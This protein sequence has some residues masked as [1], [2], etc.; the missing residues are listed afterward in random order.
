MKILEIKRHLNKPDESY[1]CD[2]LARGSDYVIVK[3][4]SEMSVESALSFL[5]RDRQ[6]LHI[7][8]PV[9][10][11]LSGRCWTRTED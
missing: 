10:G 4:V 2:L 1:L 6:L 11:A 7:T 3:Y 9:W 8:K 5:T